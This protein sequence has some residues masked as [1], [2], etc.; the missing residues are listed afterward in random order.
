MRDLKRAS[1]PHTPTRWLRLRIFLLGAFLLLFLGVVLTRA[2]ELQVNQRGKLREMA[3]DQY[4]R[5]IDLPARRGDVFD[6]WGVPLA[7]SVEVDS[8]W[9]DPSLLPD[10]RAAARSLGRTLGQ[11]GK[12]LAARFE[13]AK[14]FAWVKR[15]VTFDEV[16]RVRSLGLPGIGFAKEPKRFYP[17][18]E[19]A[20]HVLGLVGTEGKG[21]DG[22]EL[23]FDDELTGQRQRRAGV[24][25]AKGRR[26]LVAGADDAKSRQGASV[27]LTLDR[28]LQHVTETAL[29]RAVDDAKGV[30]GMAILMD[31]KT[32][33]ILALANA[34]RFNP[35]SPE[36]APAEALRNRAVT[37]A[38]EPGSTFKAFVVAAALDARVISESTTFDCEKGAW[39]VG[40]HTINDSH[41]HTTL[42]VGQVLQVS[43]NIGAAKIGQKLGRERLGEAFTKFGF[44]ERLELGLPGEA[45]GS[46]PVP[47]AEV[48][49]V[50][51]SFGQG[52]TATA[53]QL[54]AAYGALANDGVLMRP[55]LVS[56]VVDSDGVVLLENQPTPVR[57]VV[58]AKSARAVVRMLEGVVAKEGTAPKAR[59]DAYRVAGKTGTA[60]KVEPGKG[61]TDK[62]IAS[63]IGLVPAEDPRLVVLVVIDE[64]KTDVY[65]G[66]VAAPAFKEIASTAMPYL[67]VSPSHAAETLVDAA[68]TTQGAHASAPSDGDALDEAVIQAGEVRVPDLRGRVGRLA[69]ERLLTASLEP[70]LVGTGR[71]SAQQPAPGSRVP[72]GARITL[73]LTPP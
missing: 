45:K 5:D 54:V 6:R 59:M 28:Q 58:S 49:L 21:L 56:R 8:I 15:Q 35:N 47:K 14:R 50:T 12:E 33:A 52:L 1:E 69:V 67:G 37:D 61:Y 25:D 48:Q 16:E 70:R 44:G 57:S 46:L 9:V 17:Q 53:M 29:T 34:P 66:I 39:K 36:T 2:L 41:P 60:Q 63:F 68:S 72:K 7:Q 31:P 13:K 38:F 64:P 22:L 30:A 62:R 20:A 27:E 40:R 19:L 73:E 42:D 32:G 24:R 23:A 4:V 18:R 11:S 65:G 51:Q 71:V 10:S 55:Y 26:L 43:S 3:R